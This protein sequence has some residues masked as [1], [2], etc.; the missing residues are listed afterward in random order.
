MCRRQLLIR[1]GRSGGRE[2]D[3]GRPLMFYFP[4]NLRLTSCDILLIEISFN[5]RL[6]HMQSI[7]KVIRIETFNFDGPIRRYTDVV[8]DHERCEARTVD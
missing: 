4:G 5:V 1:A 3:C 2:L 7:L 8:F 6:N